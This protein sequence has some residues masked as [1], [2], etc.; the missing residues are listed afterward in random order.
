MN[1]TNKQQELRLEQSSRLAP[2]PTP[3]PSPPGGAE[4]DSRKLRQPPQ[5]GQ[6]T[7]SPLTVERWGGGEGLGADSSAEATTVLGSL[8]AIS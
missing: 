6:T 7:P 1:V 2:P 4:F 5:P 8:G 3:S